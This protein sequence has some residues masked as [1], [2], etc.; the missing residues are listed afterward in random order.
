LLLVSFGVQ[1]IAFN[2]LEN[3]QPAGEAM[4]WKEDMDHTI[5]ANVMRQ[6]RVNQLPQHNP[7]GDPRYFAAG[8]N[9]KPIGRF[10]PLNEHGVCLQRRSELVCVN[11]LTGEPVWIREGIEPGS[12][13]LGDDEYIVVIPHEGRQAMVLNA[14][15]GSLVG[16]RDVPSR[17]NRWTTLG[18]R[19]LSFRQEGRTMKVRMAD[20]VEADPADW[21]RSYAVESK[22]TIVERDKLAVLE[23]NGKFT[24]VSLEDGKTLIETQLAAPKSLQS[25]QVLASEDQYLL[26]T[27]S[28]HRETGSVNYQPPSIPDAPLMNGHVYAFSRATGQ[29]MWP[30]PAYVEQWGLPLDQPTGTPVVLLMRREVRTSGPQRNVLG[31]MCLDRRDGS[32]LF[33]KNDLAAN[34]GT[35]ND[36]YTL[37]ADPAANAVKLVLP[38]LGISLTFTDQPEPPQPPI[39]A[40][41]VGDG[42]TVNS[43]VEAVG[44]LFR[45]LGGANPAPPAVQFVPQGGAILPGAALPGVGRF[46]P[47]VPPAV[48]PPANNPFAPR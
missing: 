46:V 37:E 10:G 24:L 4:L 7:W 43:G 39:E 6:I 8:S 5:E 2:L 44:A 48:P 35:A 32:L 38:Y 22:G 27:N 33:L 19:I 42:G 11:P 26:F 20:L 29:S 21:E 41:T 1:V 18:R 45:V 14:L 12:D 23:P 47:L 9:S 17:S 36:K 28:S 31:V 25:I 16:Y 34:A 13:V 3:S 15:D 40:V 30:S